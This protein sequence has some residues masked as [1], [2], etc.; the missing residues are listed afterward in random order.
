MKI[1][2]QSKLYALETAQSENQSEFGQTLFNAQLFTSVAMAMQTGGE[3][4]CG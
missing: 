2:L 4:S 3:I 1:A